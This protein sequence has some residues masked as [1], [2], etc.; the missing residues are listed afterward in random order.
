MPMGYV[1][2]CAP[3]AGFVHPRD[4]LILWAHSVTVASTK[5]ASVRLGH[6]RCNVMRMSKRLVGNKGEQ[7]IEISVI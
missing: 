1:E 6:E 5:L 4:R 7:D 3:R 2:V